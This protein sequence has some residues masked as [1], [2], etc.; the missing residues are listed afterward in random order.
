M[1]DNGALAIDIGRGNPPA[2]NSTDGPRCSYGIETNGR[3]VLFGDRDNPHNVWIGGDGDFALDFSSSNGGF[4][5][6]PSKGTNY[7]PASVIG[8]RN[9]QGI[10][11]LTI[12]F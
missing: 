9:G 3:P 2:V 4:R 7:Y 10:P 1:V 5:S 8:F 11:S 6:E 12:L